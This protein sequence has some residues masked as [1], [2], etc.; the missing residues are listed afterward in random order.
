MYQSVFSY[1]EIVSNDTV[2]KIN[3]RHY[4]WSTDKLKL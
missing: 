1:I 4:L 2:N 3:N